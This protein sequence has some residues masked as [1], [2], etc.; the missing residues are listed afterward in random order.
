MFRVAS[1]NIRKS[2]GRDRRRRPDR[3][4]SVLREIDADIVVL[5]EVDRRFGRR[6]ASSLSPHSIAEETDYRPIDLSIRPESLGWHGNGVLVRGTLDVLGGE[7]I[8]LPCFEPRGAVVIQVAKDDQRLRI[9]G[10]HLSLLPYW[11]KRQAEAI[12]KHLAGSDGPE[13]PTLIIGD[14]NEW[15]LEGPGLEPFRQDFDHHAPGKSYPAARPVAPL[16]RLF[17]DRGL[18]VLEA[19]VHRS[20][21]ASVASDHLPIWVEVK[22]RSAAIA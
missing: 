15:F 4:L 22:G 10:A 13:V 11:R 6:R 17:V 20:P 8:A 5:Q 9:V 3:I 19:G 7:R 2:I 18:E 1:Y 12:K 14:F 21:L 16:D